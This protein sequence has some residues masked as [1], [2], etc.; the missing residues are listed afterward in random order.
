MNIDNRGFTLIEVLISLTIVSII[1]MA[2]FMSVNM[3]NK[4]NAKNEKDI[5]AMDI[6]QSQ[7]EY[8]TKEIKSKKETIDIDFNG[9]KEIN[10]TE[11]INSNEKILKSYI[12]KNGLDM[13]EGDV[14]YPKYIVQ[15]NEKENTKYQVLISLKPSLKKQ[16]EKNYYLY[17]IE[18]KVKPLTDLTKRE[19]K[20]QTKVLDNGN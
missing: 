11:D 14:D 20:I 1:S 5:Q 12:Q 15:Y 18:V 9:D 3:T 2:F 7:V 17:D 6:A 13:I 10:E 16:Q 4:E 8:L 19:A